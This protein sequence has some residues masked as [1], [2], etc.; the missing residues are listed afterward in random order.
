M[1]KVVQRVVSDNMQDKLQS[2]VVEP[3]VQVNK[4]VYTAGIR[5]LSADTIIKE[6]PL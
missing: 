6:Q 2:M 4:V 5:K 1:G 3:A